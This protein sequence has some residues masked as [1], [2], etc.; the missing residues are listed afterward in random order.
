VIV[1]IKKVTLLIKKLFNDKRLRFLLTGGINTFVG[2]G[3]C[4][5]FLY[6]GL[7]LQ[8]SLTLSTLIG[9]TNSYFWNKY[10]T[11]RTKQKSASEAFRFV[12][13]YGIS[14]CIGLLLS[15]VF[16]SYLGI[17]K[18]ISGLLC[19]VVNPVI[20]YVGHNFFSFRQNENNK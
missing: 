20:S 2:F 4:A 13:V 5:L 17:D 11:F 14:Y 18:Y 3:S 9:V 16:E 7:N 8:V 15:F 1:L 10:F 19:Q 12:L 6:C